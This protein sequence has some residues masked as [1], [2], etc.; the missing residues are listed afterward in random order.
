M[1]I[2][3]FIDKISDDKTYCNCYVTNQYADN[4]Q[5]K[6]NLQCYLELIDAQYK[7]YSPNKR[8]LL[9][10]EAPGYRGCRVCGIPFTSEQIIE[11]NTFFIGER[12][13]NRRIPQRLH[14]G[15]FPD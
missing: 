9:V 5:A 1:T 15:Q 6:H 8:I 10:G 2:S 3:D 13:Q 4:A 14:N 7:T 12:L 11:T